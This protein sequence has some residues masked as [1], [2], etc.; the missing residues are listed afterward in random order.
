MPW[1]PGQSGNPEGRRIDKPYRDALLLALHRPEDMKPPPGK[2]SRLVETALKKAIED[3]DSAMIRDTAD[4]LDGKVP[5]GI[6]GGAENDAPLKV[7]F[8]WLK[9]S[10]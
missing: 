2:L 10:E 9:H 6:I 5:Q 4:R 8:E 1:K 7:T 3:G